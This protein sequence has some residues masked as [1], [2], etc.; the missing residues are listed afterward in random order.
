MRF[1][2][3][4]QN[5]EIAKDKFYSYEYGKK[6]ILHDDL[7]SISDKFKENLNIEIDS[8]W[9]LLEGAFLIN[10]NNWSLSND[11]RDIYLQD[12]TKRKSLTNNIPFLQ[13]YQGNVCFYCGEQ[14]DYDEIHVDHLLPRQVIRTDDIWNLVLSHA[15]CNLD[16]SDKIVD[17]YYIE[18]LYNRNENI[19]GSN[20]PW[21]DKIK[22]ALGDN[23]I[24]RRRSLM[25][26][27][28]NVK[29]ILG[30]RY[31]GGV[32]GYIPEND[33]FYRRLITILNSANKI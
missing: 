5:K 17:I 33:P 27:Y 30:N 8:R 2:N 12:G 16:K 14:L 28:E 21:K 32:K 13:G 25:Q 20:H 29:S 15:T 19:M 26:H 4:G 6:I 3:V 1:H 23:P 24:K 10:R 31:W 18:K 9:N 22:A 11:L 7:L